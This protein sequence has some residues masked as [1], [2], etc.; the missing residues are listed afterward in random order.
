[1]TPTRM[2]LNS[3][4]EPGV[5]AGYRL[6]ELDSINRPP[7]CA[8]VLQPIY[9]SERRKNAGQNESA[10]DCVASAGLHHPDPVNRLLPGLVSGN[11]G[12]A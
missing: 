5:S 11:R 12:G 8:A 2:P 10:D 1:M 4:L 9:E 3:T 7:E 6:I